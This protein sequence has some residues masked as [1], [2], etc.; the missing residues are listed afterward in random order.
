[1]EC[2]VLFFKKKDFSFH[3]ITF[4]QKRGPA[5]KCVEFYF[6]VKVS[7][8]FK[9]FTHSIILSGLQIN[10]LK[11]TVV[12]CS[13]FLRFP[14]ILQIHVIII[15]EFLLIIILPFSGIVHR[16]RLTWENKNHNRYYISLKKQNNPFFSNVCLKC[17]S[18]A[19]VF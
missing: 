6:S 8:G 15:N 3:R 4:L 7:L 11:F 2:D 14:M 10:H 18:S 16:N 5:L 9:N 19:G 12:Y 17:D 1:M 13:Q